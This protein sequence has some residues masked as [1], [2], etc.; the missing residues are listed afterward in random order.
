MRNGW[1]EGGMDRWKDGV[2]EG[3]RGGR[4]RCRGGM[5]TSDRGMEGRSYIGMEGGKRE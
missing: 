5:E 2:R 3:G 4:E 1:R